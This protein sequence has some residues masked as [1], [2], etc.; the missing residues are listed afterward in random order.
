M[1]ILLLFDS[2]KGVPIA[3]IDSVELT[4]IRTGALSGVATKYMARQNVE[5]VTLIGSGIQAWTQL[6]AVDTIRRISKVYVYSV[7]KANREEFA[8]KAA[9][10]FDFEINAVDNPGVYAKES[11][12]IIAATNS[13]TPVLYGRWIS[14][15]VHVNSIG[16]LPNRRELEDDVIGR[17]SKIVADVKDSVLREAGDIIH[18]IKNNVITRDKII[19]LE[20]LVVRGLGRR[21]NEREVTLF[22]SVGFAAIDLYTASYVYSRSLES[23]IGRDVEF[24]TT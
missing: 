8:K 19:E 12:L 4:A 5:V 16:V 3:L 9:E 15:G 17:A 11:D 7:T 20:D 21:E 2:E 10:V 13:A 24:R 14:E 22:K 1:G 18:A 6:E 23:N